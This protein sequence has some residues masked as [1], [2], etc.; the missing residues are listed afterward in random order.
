MSKVVKLEDSTSK[1]VRAKLNEG[2]YHCLWLVFCLA[3]VAVQV[4]QISSQFF[5]YGITT[6]VQLLIEDDMEVPTI[7]FCFELI[8]TI[9]W[10]KTTKEERLSILHTSDGRPLLDYD[11]EKENSTEKIP[12]LLGGEGDYIQRLI[13]TSGFQK[14]GV[15]RM[16]QLTYDI[17]WII[18]MMIVYYEHNPF[19]GQRKSYYPIPS[20]EF[21]Q[22]FSVKTFFKDRYK[23]FLFERKEIDRT[24]KY[25]HVMR[26]PINPEVIYMIALNA[27]MVPTVKHLYFIMTPNNHSLTHGFFSFVPI[28]LSDVEGQLVTYDKFQRTLLPKPYST[29]CLNYTTLGFDSRGQCY[30][31]CVQNAVKKATHGTRIPPSINIDSEVKEKIIA[32]D[33]LLDTEV[34]TGGNETFM[35]LMDRVEDVCEEKCKSQDCQ[36]SNY[37]PEKLASVKIGRPVLGLSAPQSPTVSATCQEAVSIVQY[38]TDVFSAL[39][40]W[41]GISAFGFAKF[42]KN[43]GRAV[44]NAYFA[45]NAQVKRC[46][47][48]KMKSQKHVR[49]KKAK[50]VGSMAVPSKPLMPRVHYKQRHQWIELPPVRYY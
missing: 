12:V 32:F 48:K 33:E 1:K 14:L 42:C 44:I 15:S 29:K 5:A 20:Q 22:V 24:L 37:I 17:T 31:D 41:L 38:L 35:Q 36:S 11:V 28:A 6:N 23:C 13:L 25:Y 26:N 45:T 50:N 8:M 7:S 27:F 10:E 40:F 34:I 3:G 49:E 39:G 18:N 16:F 46:K 43:S 9:D 21:G 4:Y 30:E 2:K 19:T 47:A